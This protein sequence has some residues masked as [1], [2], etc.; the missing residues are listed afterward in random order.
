MKN[1]ETFSE[2]YIELSDSVNSCFNLGQR[3]LNFKVVRKIL[4]YVLDRFRPKVIVIE[5][6]KDMNLMRV[7]EL[8]GSLQNY[9]ITLATFS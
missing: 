3:I 9:E 7:D 2:F 4:R 1:D 8:V 5:E 6:S